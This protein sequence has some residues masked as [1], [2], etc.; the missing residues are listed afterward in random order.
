[1]PVPDRDERIYGL[2]DSVQRKI[3]NQPEKGGSRCVDSVCL[4]LRGGY[5]ARCSDR[6]VL[7][8]SFSC[9]LTQSREREDSRGGHFLAPPQLDQD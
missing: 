9:G 5:P 1:M 4:D 7:A 2:H 3:P 6:L 8:V